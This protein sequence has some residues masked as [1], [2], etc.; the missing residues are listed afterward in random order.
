MV[1]RSS[2]SRNSRS[3]S[4]ALAIGTLRDGALRGYTLQDSLQNGFGRLSIGV[5]VEVQNDAMTQ[6]RRCYVQDIFHGKV[7]SPAEES[8]HTSAF[9]QRL[10]AARRAAV[11]DVPL[12]QLMRLGLVGLSGHH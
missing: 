5:C 4:G 6:H 9:H 2:F 3:S 12:G 7:E 8:A 1:S 11:A 10:R